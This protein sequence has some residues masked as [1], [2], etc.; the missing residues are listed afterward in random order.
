MTFLNF[1]T[2]SP[3]YWGDVYQTTHIHS[4]LFPVH[5]LPKAFKDLLPV[6]LSNFT[7]VM[8]GGLHTCSWPASWSHKSGL[9]GN[10]FILDPPNVGLSHHSSLFLHT[11]RPITFIVVLFSSN[12][13]ILSPKKYNNKIILV[14]VSVIHCDYCCEM[15]SSI[16]STLIITLILCNINS[17]TTHQSL[18][19]YSRY[20]CPLQIP[21]SLHSPVVSPHPLSELASPLPT[22]GSSALSLSPSV[23]SLSVSVSIT[24]R[25][26]LASSYDTLTIAHI[27]SRD[28]DI[29][30]V[31]I[32]NQTNKKT[33]SY[34]LKLPQQ[35]ILASCWC[36]KFVI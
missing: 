19:H 18:S 7:V 3:L 27:S 15:C 2:S 12:C 4:F 29:A 22:S 24:G 30:T 20:L 36:K 16:H 23:L 21:L 17:Y 26:L 9:L 14:C 10:L 32:K 6:C 33:Q 34:Q 11:P 28:T 31:K 1:Q 13:V 8:L 35:V 25:S 5:V